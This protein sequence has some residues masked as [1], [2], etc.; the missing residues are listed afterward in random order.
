MRKLTLALL[1]SLGMCSTGAFADGV[2]YSGFALYFGRSTQPGEQSVASGLGIVRTRRL[3]EYYGYEMQIGMFDNSGPYT[4]NT[5][6]ELS[7]IGIMP[8]GGS[9]YKLYGKLGIADVYSTGSVEA[10]NKLGPTYGAGVE[11]VREVGIIRVGIQHF[12]LGNTPSL[13]T[14]MIG[15]SLFLN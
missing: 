13:R 10:A 3:S 6:A 5:F 7:A 1:A 4:A 2:A 14:N 12:N 8:L 9:G 15:L 11:F